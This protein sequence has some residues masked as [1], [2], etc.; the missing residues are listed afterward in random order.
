LAVA[1]GL[2]HLLDDNLLGR[3]CGDAAIFERRQRIGDRVA[4]LRGWMAL[5]GFLQS[6]LVG[7]IFDGFHYQHVAGQ[8]QITCFRLDL[9]VHV[10]F[11]AIA[12]ASSLG[13]GVFHRCDHDAA[14]DRLLARDRIGN[15]Q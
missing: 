7:R 12:R 5:A 10:G 13:D 1:L 2:A 15:L 8:P 14:V 4:D 3:L 11:R 6:D 9:G